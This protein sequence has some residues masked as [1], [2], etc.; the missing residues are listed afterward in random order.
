MTEEGRADW[1]P[2]ETD[3]ARDAALGLDPTGNATFAAL[4]AALLAGMTAAGSRWWRAR[5]RRR[6]A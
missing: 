2:V 3:Q 4:V 6:D 5:R 1:G